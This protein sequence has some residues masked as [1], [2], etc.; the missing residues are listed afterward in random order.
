[1]QAAQKEENLT[2]YQK[3]SK[4]LKEV[5]NLL[6]P[7]RLGFGLGLLAVSATVFLIVSGQKSEK[8]N[9][10]TRPLQA[11]IN[12]SK[13]AGP[14]GSPVLGATQ[15]AT[16]A[17]TPARTV[18]AVSKPSASGKINVNTAS[19]AQLDTLPQIGPVT[20]KAIIDYRTAHGPFKSVNQLDNVK[21]IGPKTI[22]KIKNLITI[23]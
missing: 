16:A 9:Y 6:E 4:R 11:E 21:G 8:L 22:D 7:Y 10:Q 17:V 20:A 23:E 15:E 18:K 12:T 2:R 3:I 14:S 19:L 5:W 13:E 1:M